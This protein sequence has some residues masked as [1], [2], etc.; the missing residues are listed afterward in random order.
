MHIM[1]IFTFAT[2]SFSAGQ[3]KS[4]NLQSAWISHTIHKSGKKI[5]PEVDPTKL[6]FFINIIV[7]FLP[8]SLAIS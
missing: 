2:V 7:R 8:L 1:P 4:H 5:R 3:V 6:F